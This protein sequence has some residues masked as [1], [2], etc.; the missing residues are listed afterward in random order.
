MTLKVGDSESN[1]W[2]MFEVVDIGPRS[3]S[4]ALALTSNS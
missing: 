4:C 1:G 3:P 2:S